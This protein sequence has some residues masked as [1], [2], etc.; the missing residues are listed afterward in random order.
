M[1]FISSNEVK[2]CVAQ[3]RQMK[4]M[5]KPQLK[6]TLFH[7][8]RWNKSHIHSKNLNILNILYWYVVLMIIFVWKETSSSVENL[9]SIEASC[10]SDSGDVQVDLRLWIC[11]P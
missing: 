5:E 10:L 6:Y 3:S 4:K 9:G 1:M 11:M 2:K 7:F 8:I